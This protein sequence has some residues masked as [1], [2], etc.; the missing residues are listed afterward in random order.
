MRVGVQNQDFYL[1]EMKSYC[2]K[3][4][5]EVEF[6]EAGSSN[7][8]DELRAGKYDVFI[9]GS[10]YHIPN[11]KIVGKMANR[12]FYYATS[13]GNPEILEQLE[14]ALQA[15]RL[16]Q[17]DFQGDL[18]HKYY[19]DRLMG[20]PTYTKEEMDI[21]KAYPKL[22]VEI[23]PWAVPLQY[24]DSKT[25]EGRGIVVDLLNE[26][27]KQC[28]IEFEYIPSTHDTGQCEGRADLYASYHKERYGVPM[29][30]TNK[31][32]SVPMVF[33][34]PKALDLS[35]SLT[36]GIA[37]LDNIDV[38]QL[39]KRYPDIAIQQYYAI[40]DVSEVLSREE[41]DLVVTSLYTFNELVK[42]GN[43]KNYLAYPTGIE[44]DID[45]G[46]I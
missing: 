29:Y 33:V 36:A 38:N 37:Q 4:N 16:N 6:V 26:I 27:G 30:L 3:N 24:I 21:I 34:A 31:I 9:S 5:I 40:T 8:D 1:N 35:K 20:M 12:P 7:V 45:L 19:G 22:V 23:E 41:N 10:L 13:K 11:I 15:I 25:G 39:A 44:L 17:V 18:Y 14:E 42:Y 2:H 28:G 32:L 46:G 43:N